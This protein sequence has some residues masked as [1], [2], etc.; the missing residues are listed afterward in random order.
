LD[1]HYKNNKHHPEWEDYNI[2]E[3]KDIKD[4]EGIYQISNYGDIKRLSHTVERKKQGN[5]NVPEIILKASVT[6]KGYL[7]IQ[8]SK[9]GSKT[10]YMVHRL[11]ALHFINNLE[12]KPQINHKDTNKKNNYYK[13][14]EWCDNSEN[15]LHAYKNDLQKIKYIVHCLELNLTTLGCG[16]MK[17]KLKELGYKKARESS[18]LNCINGNCNS[19]LKLHF[20]GSLLEEYQRSKLSNMNL[21]DLVEMFCDWLAATKRHETGNIHNSIKI[22]KERFKYDD[23]LTSIFENT[24]L[25]LEERLEIAE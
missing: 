9:N 11:V 20:E 19:H 1:H 13:N 6:P 25:L 14:L 23:I 15:Q 22:N 21:V 17:R 24:S 16:E 12:D 8:L 18:I 10:N 7:R 5:F 2:L 3:W 4:Y